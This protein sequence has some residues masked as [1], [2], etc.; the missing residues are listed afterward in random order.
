[1]PRC[2]PVRPPPASSHRC[3][4]RRGF[5]APAS[6][7][8]TGRHAC[9]CGLAMHGSGDPAAAWP[10]SRVDAAIGALCRETRVPR[11]SWNRSRRSC[12]RAY[13]RHRR[14]PRRDPS[15]RPRYSSRAS[16]L[17]WSPRI[18]AAPCSLS[19]VAYTSH[20]APTRAAQ[21]G[22]SC[23]VPLRVRVLRPLPRRD[24]RHVFLRIEASQ[25]WPS[26]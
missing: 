19:P 24:L 13:L 18:P 15:L 16:S 9:R 22:L 25:T 14:C 20:A 2:L 3:P 11:G 4:P 17:L 26:P 12:P 5:V 7:L 6:T 23:F 8:P 1:M 21:T 10:H